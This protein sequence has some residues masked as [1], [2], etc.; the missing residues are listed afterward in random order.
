MWIRR[1]HVLAPRMAEDSN[2][3]EYGSE[4]AAT[5]AA[6]AHAATEREIGL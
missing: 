4:R 1:S 6:A 2:E 5:A 3:D